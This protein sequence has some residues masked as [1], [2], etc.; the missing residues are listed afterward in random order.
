MISF[1][2][3]SDGPVANITPKCSFE[4]RVGI[5]TIF[6]VIRRLGKRAKETYAFLWN[7]LLLHENVRASGVCVTLSVS[8]C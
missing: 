6:R 5:P 4:N 1:T 2:K 3:L 7:K 8:A